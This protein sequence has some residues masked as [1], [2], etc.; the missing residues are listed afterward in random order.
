MRGRDFISEEKKIGRKHAMYLRNSFRKQISN[1]RKDTGRAS[2]PGYRVG[3]RQHMLQSIA[4]QTVKYTF[5][6]HLGVDTLRKANSPKGGPVLHR[7]AHPFKLK[8]TIADIS[9]PEKILNGLADDI[10]EL[11]GDLILSEASKQWQ[12]KA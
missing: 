5:I 2:K 3:F 12:I 1:L 6:N 4:V 10:S 7:Q 11:R 8:P 9:I